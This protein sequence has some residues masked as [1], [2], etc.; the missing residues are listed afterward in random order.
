MNYFWSGPVNTNL[1]PGLLNKNQGPRPVNTNWRL[2]PRAG[3]HKDPL[4]L[5]IAR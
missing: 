3:K 4:S 2:D 1:G 5:M